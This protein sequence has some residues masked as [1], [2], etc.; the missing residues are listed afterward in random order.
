[1]Q[2]NLLLKNFRVQT[3]I[4]R[5][6]ILKHPVVSKKKIKEDEITLKGIRTRWG[7]F[8]TSGIISAES[9]CEVRGINI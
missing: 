5:N 2:N 1:M 4:K 3:L 9:S 7:V 6:K 8:L